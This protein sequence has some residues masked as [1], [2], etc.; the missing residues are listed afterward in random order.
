M[1]GNPRCFELDEAPVRLGVGKNMVHA[2][3]YWL[4]AA[5]M[6]RMTPEGMLATALGDRLLSEDGW[7]P[8]LE[9]EGTLWL[10]HWL[11][12]ANPEEASATGANTQT[13]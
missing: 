7:D 3:R 1:K 9:D 10:I 2:I 8:Y 11:L 6:A 5:R 12:A 4:R 13:R